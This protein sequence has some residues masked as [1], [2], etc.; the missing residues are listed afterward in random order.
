MTFALVVDDSLV[1]Q[2]L[3]GRVLENQL[4]ITI[5]Y[6]SDGHEALR[7]IK[8]QTPD[9]VITDLQMPKM[10]GLE[11]VEA[12]RSEY[13]T[14]PVVIM[15][16]VG[17]EELA[18]AALRS[19]ANS[20]VPKRHLVE[21]LAKVVKRQ[22]TLAGFDHD[23]PALECLREIRTEFVLDNDCSRVVP[24]VRYLKDDLIRVG[25]FRETTTMHVGLAVEE[26]VTNAIHYGDLGLSSELRDKDAEAFAA[27]LHQRSSQPPY[28]DRRVRVIAELS[29]SE[30]RY[31]V[32]D[33]GEGFDT[34][35]LPDPTDPVNL[36][37]NRR[38]GLVLIHTFMDEVSH[39][40]V[41]NQITMIKRREL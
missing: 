3:A 20:Y 36:E 1:D 21:D 9:V 18:A 35:K 37:Q 30:A 28:C 13:P 41:G 25:V 33:D 39:N 24:L 29:R 22:F 10:H 12:I 4:D 26:A 14:L 31:V 6:A 11:L 7:S 2:R 15:T 40:D 19:G 34:S 38:R 27:L 23:R 17:S 16:S 5:A 32:C 8:E